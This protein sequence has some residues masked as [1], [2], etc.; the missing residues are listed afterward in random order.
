MLHILTVFVHD[1]HLIQIGRVPVIV[2][3]HP[4]GIVIV[5]MSNFV[6][7]LTHPSLYQR[8]PRL[9]GQPARA[10]PLLWNGK[11]RSKAHPE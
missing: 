7:K 11:D 10:I 6:L 8:D 1:L 2:D 9:D 3:Y 4:D 5:G